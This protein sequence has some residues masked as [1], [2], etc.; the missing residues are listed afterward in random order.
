MLFKEILYSCGTWQ[1]L[2]KLK[3]RIPGQEEGYTN[4]L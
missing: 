4:P 1:Q 3:A 2:I